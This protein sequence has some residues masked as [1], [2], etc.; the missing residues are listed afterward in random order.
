MSD[1]GAPA[2]YRG[3]RLQAL[4]A[5]KRLL[6][7]GLDPELVFHLE[8]Y[9]DLDIERVDGNLV[10]AIQVKSYQGLVLS[11]L[12]PKKKNGFFRRALLLL[13]RQDPPSVK[14]VNYGSIGKEMSL[15]WQGDGKQRRYVMDK[16]KGF[17]YSS[18]DIQTLFDQVELVELN[19]ADEREEVYAQ[20][21]ERLTGI[22]PASAFG[23]LNFWLYKQS[24]SKARVT[25]LELMQQI[26]NIGS[27][28]S[29][30]YHYHQEWFT[31]IKPIEDETIDVAHL[32]D[33]RK[34][35]YAGVSARYEHI[36][37][38]L[39]F[40][41][42]EKLAEIAR[43]FSL[44]KVVILHAASGQG[45]SALAYRYLHEAYPDQWRFSIETIENRRHALSIAKALSGHARA[46]QA[47]MAIY[48]DVAPTD[49]DWPEL[50]RQLS[51]EPYF[52]IL[53]TI[54]EEDFQRASISNAFNYV[55]VDL[56]FHETEARLIYGRARQVGFAREHLNFED[57]WH[58]FGSH[59]PLMEY[60][61]LLTQTQTLR[62]RLEEQINR[63]RRE[64]RE[65]ILSRD[66]LEL[67]RLVATASAYEARVHLPTLLE[68]LGLPEPG[69]TLDYYDAEY[70]LKVTPD[71][72]YVTGLHPIRSQIIVD[73]LT[74]PGV[75]P[76]LR[77]AK[78][79]IMLIP[80]DDWE[81]FFLQAFVNRQD[82]FNQILDLLMA[83]RPTTWTGFGGV[84]HCLIW[85]G[86][87]LY[88]EENRVVAQSARNF[89][90]SAWHF[91][92]DLNFAG[93]DAPDLDG[94]WKNF[95]NLLAE[96]RQAEIERIRRS[97]T[98][99]EG[100]FRFA[101]AWLHNLDIAPIQPSSSKDWASI[102]ECLYW[103]ARLGKSGDV[104]TWLSDELL[105]SSIDSLSIALLAELS[106]G[107]YTTNPERC[108]AWL[109]N[110][111]VKLEVKLANELDVMAIEETADKLSIHFLTYPEDE[112]EQT[113]D[114]KGVKKSLHDQ[115]IERLQIVRLLF[116]QYN[117]YGTQ[118]YGHRLPILGL[119]RL[120]DTQKSGVE[121]KYLPPRWPIWANGIA[122]GLI[123]YGFRPNNWMEYLQE[124]V[125]T[126]QGIV[127]C[128][129]ELARG[130][131]LYFRRDKAYN[132]AKIEAISGGY[133]GRIMLS[134]KEPPVF[135]KTAV[136]VSMLAQS[137][138]KVPD[139]NQSSAKVFPTSILEQIYKPYR[140]TERG[141]FS[142][143]ANFMQQSVHVMV[144]NYHAGKLPEDSPQKRAVMER[145]KQENINTEGQ[146]LS[147]NYL[148]EA[149]SAL[150]SYQGSFK[151]LFDSYLG[152]GMLDELEKNERDT[153]NLLWMLWHYYANHP[154]TAFT[155][156]LKQA[157]ARIN[158]IVQ[159]I[160]QNY[161]KALEQIQEEG[162]RVNRIAMELFWEDS[163]AIWILLDLDDPIQMYPM[164]EA[165]ILA[166]RRAV[167]PVEPASIV[168]S[169]IS[170]HFKYTVIV[171]TVRGKMIN[172]LVWP[173]RTTFTIT[174]NE[175]L[176]K[177]QWAYIPQQAPKELLV[178]IGVLCWEID[179]IV[180]AN[181]LSASVQGLAL[182]ILMLASLNE[183]PDPTE[184]GLER[185]QQ[186]MG[187]R[188]DELSKLLQ[189]FLDSGKALLDRYNNLS[190]EAKPEQQSYLAE[191][192][193][194]LSEVHKQVLPS[195]D[196]T[197]KQ[198]L[199]MEDLISY[200]ERL[201]SATNQIE[202]IKLLWI[203]STLMNYR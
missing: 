191:A 171:P 19:K 126:R 192:V 109:Q 47:P 198:A 135:P 142:G 42:E 128:F 14:L 174:T 10:E 125:D 106:F 201:Q 34:E 186:F 133:W 187:K 3:Y 9:E 149:K 86:I 144:V 5:L 51:H 96:D 188:S 197:G 82:D 98:P 179:D 64:V 26:Q 194:G 31:S 139:E 18:G 177:T 134:A 94:W 132:V 2:A 189:T 56:S 50:I 60:I 77:A 32:P 158:A 164:I 55:P 141:Y 41:R 131:A 154:R 39:D 90:G 183:I 104:N 74:E 36:L 182:M 195:G 88:V 151:T 129:S 114:E 89:F 72:Q 101:K 199:S 172:A 148:S 113:N 157:P 196:F 122:S 107:L 37:A 163:P 17:D 170:N 175:P 181:Q 93:D 130:I 71:N 44:S 180:L 25:Q 57:A 33:L 52:Q 53:V 28:L 38:D 145:L 99:K 159:G 84:L 123:Q 136:D 147:F 87:K 65:K 73:L 46:V 92:M 162:I 29:D 43:A 140:E 8:G 70:L 185:L 100:A 22:D 156:P 166:L 146:F 1:L 103:A 138:G 81:I 11:N 21:S 118:G 155:D 91:I 20:L 193:G 143:I 85:A 45:K 35:F 62:Q 127:S 117:Q 169:L 124:I 23:L 61:Y 167:G 200:A 97:Q 54:R 69:M 95:G 102:A 105:V 24:E 178:K 165:L 12:S 68:Q 111:R 173:L 112:A 83:L 176:E 7:P 76:W 202:I 66:E 120:D 59:G 137:K 184:V 121:K 75:Y 190:E 67:L 119:D 110:N 160:L 153:L 168:H 150:L 27:F 49:R 108:Q 80:E 13:Q 40:R 16:L 152:T 48:I 58:N 4:Y 15:A 161:D 6:S 30:R 116:P 203:A 115:T 63:L 78:R 79:T